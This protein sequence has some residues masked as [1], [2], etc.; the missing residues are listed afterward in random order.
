MKAMRLPVVAALDGTYM[1][2]GDTGVYKVWFSHLGGQWFCDC[3]AKA[4]ARCS[5][6]LAVEVYIKKAASAA[7]KVQSI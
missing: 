7:E 4:G 6:R 2:G 3:Q 1:V 5:H